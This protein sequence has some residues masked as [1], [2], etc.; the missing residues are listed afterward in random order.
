MTVAL[1]DD[2]DGSGVVTAMAETALS[3]GASVRA[4]LGPFESARFEQEDG[5]MDIDFDLVAGQGFE[6]Y[7]YL[8]P[9]GV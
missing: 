8:L 2:N 3:G 6:V 5:D 4:L 7:A 1:A 9:K